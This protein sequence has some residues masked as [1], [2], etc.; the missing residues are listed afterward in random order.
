M[1][2][3]GFDATQLG[4]PASFVS[5]AQGQFFPT[6]SFTNYTG[7]GQAG[8]NHDTSTNWYVTATAN[9]AF[10]SHAFKWGADLRNNLDNIPNYSLGTFNFGNN[11]TQQNSQNSDAASGNAFAGYLLGWLTSG[12]TNYNATPA[13][14]Y[15]VYGF[16]LQDDWR[17][18]HT[19]TLNLG[20]RWDYEGPVTERYNRIN[21][22]FD[23][24]ATSP[25]N[26]PGYPLQGGLTFLTGG[27]RLP[28][29]RDL[30][31]FA[32]RIGVA[33]HPLK[34]TVFR[35]G[36]GLSYVPTFVTPSQSG[37][38]ASTSS[39]TSLDGNQTPN[40]HLF[41][42]FPAGLNQPT[43]N[44]QGLATFIGQGVSYIYPDRRIPYI[45]QYS[46]GF[47]HELPAQTLLDISYVGSHTGKLAVSKNL[48]NLTVDQLA[49]GTTYLNTLVTNPFYGYVPATV[50]IGASKTVTRRTLMVPFPQFSSVTRNGTPI[51][52]SWY[53]S[54]QIQIT[55]RLS[56]GLH[57][58]ANYTWSATMEAV[59]YLNNQFPDNALERVRTAED[60]PHRANIL[61]GYILPFFQHA[62]GV[63]R[64]VL[65]GWQIQ[66]IGIYQTGR[67]LTGVD[68]YPTGVDW[69][70]PGATFQP[71]TAVFNACT[72]TTAGV[73]QS[74]TSADQPVAW[75]QRP[76]DTLRVTSTRW[77]QIR[78]VR[79]GLWD[80]SIFKTFYPK[81]GVNVQ[82][83]CEAFNALN[84]PWFGVPNSSLGNTRF[85]LANNTQ[86]NDPRNVQVALKIAF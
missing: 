61:A 24:S 7:F 31:N 76:T 70:I 36:Y 63:R 11:W 20:V 53:N 51:G 22:G 18:T 16:F 34:N 60:L 23:A 73:R 77:S 45:Q 82:F 50:T 65:G 52:K 30:N 72:L 2:G 3:G 42:P 10:R 79:P 47:Q 43:G 21:A 12:V 25:L 78:E 55:K 66:A 74:C 81:E 8:N 54:L 14:G 84:T 85:G 37:F 64:S 41:N 9:K 28:N 71:D 29:N 4:L 32:P 59:S 56:H 83:R 26:I 80:A 44:T 6:M 27:N 57:F 33:W 19:L 39:I 67:Q 15:R 46:F 75:I 40:A 48:D 68:A 13:W 35:G 69:S 86:A 62:K 58:Q 49:L 5:A 38:A 17:V 1:Y